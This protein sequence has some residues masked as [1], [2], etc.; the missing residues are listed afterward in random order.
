MM[1]RIAVAAVVSF[2]IVLPAWL[3]LP[4]RSANAVVAPAVA[5]AAPVA[6][7]KSRRE[8]MARL[9]AETAA[10]RAEATAREVLARKAAEQQ[11]AQQ[12]A[13]R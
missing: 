7:A 1:N 9:V 13:S 12:T 10:A 2:G 8:Q 6:S 5:G 11:A 3:L 4:L